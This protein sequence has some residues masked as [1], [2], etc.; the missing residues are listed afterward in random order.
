MKPQI[1]AGIFVYW[2]QMEI[3][4]HDICRCNGVEIFARESALPVWCSSSLALKSKLNLAWVPSQRDSS[5]W[6]VV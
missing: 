4:K 1:V 3:I 5:G 2:F 6:G